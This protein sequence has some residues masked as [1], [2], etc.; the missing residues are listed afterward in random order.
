[1]HSD[2]MNSGLSEAILTCM[3]DGVILADLEG[4]IQYMNPTAEQITEC[5]FE[6][7]CGKKFDMVLTLHNNQTGE[8]V[9]SPLEKTIITNKVTGMKKDTV[10]I[11][12]D[13]EKK[14]ISAT[15]SPV[16]NSDGE[17]T[18][19]VVVF[20]DVTKLRM[21]ELSLENEGN[22]LKAILN[23]TPAGV[24]A[25]DETGLISHMNT[26]IIAYVGKTLEEVRGKNIGYGISCKENA[27]NEKDCGHVVMC[28][29]CK[30]KIAI[31]LALKEGKTSDNIELSR[32]LIRNGSVNTH[33]FR[34][35]VVPITIDGKRN[36]IITIMNITDRKNKEVAITKSRDFCINL[37]NQLPVLV[38]STDLNMKFDYIGQ[39]W[40]DYTGKGLDAMIVEGWTDC[41]HPDDKD[42]YIRLINENLEKR[43]PFEHEL[44]LRR[45]DGQLRD[46][47]NAGA[48]FYDMDGKFTGFVGTMYDVTD[49]KLF[50]EG[51]KRYKMLSQNARD[52]IFFTDLDGRIIEANK[53]AVN[54][55][56]YSY[57]ELCSMNIC[58]ISKYGNSLHNKMEK[59]MGKGI[60]FETYDFRKDGSTFPV[61]VSSQGDIIGGKQV[62]L[63]IVRDITERKKA[64]LQIRES[65]AKY[66]SLFMNLLEAFAYCRIVYDDNGNLEDFIVTEI[67]TA[68]ME[69]FSVRKEEV[70]E[71][72]CTE[73]LPTVGSYLLKKLKESQKEDRRIGD[74]RI[75]ECYVK[76]LNQWY[77]FMIFE[78][79]KGYLA[80]TIINISEKINANVE[81]EKAKEAAE[82]ANRAK[83]EFLANM[84]HEIRTPINGMI[85]MIELTLLAK[86]D[87]EQ[88]DNLITAKT[89]ADSLL[90]IINDILD[91]SKMEAGKM[92]IENI[93]FNVGGL[94][95][96]LMKI[97]SVNA[98]DKGIELSY[99]FS[100]SIPEY[101]HGD[102]MRLRQILNNLIGNAIKFT[103]K[104]EV[105]VK[106]RK[107]AECDN[108]VELKFSV[109][110][111]GIGIVN[112]DINKLFMTFSQLD[113]SFTKKHNG[114]GLGLKI[115]KQLVEMMGGKIW[116]NSEKGRGSTFCFT[117]KF[118]KGII[119]NE[120]PKQVQ[121]VNKT[122]NTLN[123]L[124][125]DDDM[126]SR[127]VIER[128]LT[129]KGHLV[130]VAQNGREAVE[131]AEKSI[132]NVILMDIQMPEM[133]GIEASRRIHELE[134]TVRYTPIIALTAYALKGDR[135]KF[136]SMGID[137]YISKPVNMDELFYAI[138]SIPAYKRRQQTPE[139]ITNILVNE[140]GEV[141]FV[142]KS[143]TELKEESL[144]ILEKIGEGIKELL[145]IARSSDLL[146]VEKAANR[147][148]I[149]S[150][151]INADE[152]KS[153]AFKVELA[154]RRGNLEDAI[155]QAMK[156]MD[157]YVIFKKIHI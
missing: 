147:V 70:I 110:D 54:A 29:N 125:V 63:S 123:I 135:E 124:V 51:L 139:S 92:T 94:I 4:R 74:V 66:Y 64:E 136:L 95:S 48:P 78:P 140:S 90:N 45:H 53:A 31:D 130:D 42:K 120:K 146:A 34:V 98:S 71:K 10:L 88:R 89:C 107:I 12:K 141:V 17:A 62:F 35:S 36:V 75:E 23:G 6:E 109:S 40:I 144:P 113:V 134:G 33:W 39:N 87:S 9:V 91:F 106:V 68:F 52:I 149:L 126:L 129:E 65:Q 41:F 82:A 57:E 61:E 96:D 37:L 104:G 14:Y 157:E 43:E 148:K 55:Y 22:N 105:S 44:R 81:L 101:L 153:A 21:M 58:N 151:D 138:D 50:E 16:K 154:A 3:G 84:S 115:S 133:D 38:W 85:G 145:L 5:R 127:K 24:I 99:E 20:R 128:M 80:T 67:N 18:G 32:K 76:S 19:V 8:K 47:L 1:M 46:F 137:E 30:L 156:L 15:C 28:R 131:K 132:Y 56:G 86:L 79:E 49:K 111:T 121:Q 13:G 25:L 155:R 97:H 27:E 11:K 60:T 142:E 116:V 112:E 69:M 83:S 118:R 2:T 117:L 59:L 7:V 119:I 77:C 93:N 143:K 73:L 26:A 103:E 102:P 150:G 100:S 72:K 108:G 114:T 152:I 122:L